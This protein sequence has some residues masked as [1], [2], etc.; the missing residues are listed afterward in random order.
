[1]VPQAEIH[2]AITGVDRNHLRGAML[3]HAVAESAGGGADVKT[4]LT[5]EIDPPVLQ[6]FLK[7]E[8]APADVTQIVAEQAKRRGGVDGSPGFVNLLLVDQSFAG[9]IA[10]WRAFARGRQATLH[11]Q[12]VETRLQQA[13]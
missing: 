12:F 3:Q 5:V 2:L 4:H 7:F 11:Q 1:M 8:A 6:S 13:S 9:E 10:R